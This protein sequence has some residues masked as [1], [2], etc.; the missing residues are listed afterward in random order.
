M[1]SE[2]KVIKV[3]DPVRNVFCSVPIE[4]ARRLLQEVDKISAAIAKAD[5][6]DNMPESDPKPEKAEAIVPDK[7]ISVSDDGVG[8]EKIS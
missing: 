1:A 5:S 8:E 2:N 6:P 3:Y 4:N 7:K